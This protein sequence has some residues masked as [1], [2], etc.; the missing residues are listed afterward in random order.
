MTAESL[1]GRAV[2]GS[3]APSDVE[4]DPVVVHGKRRLAPPLPDW[5]KKN[6]NTPMNATPT[7]TALEKKIA[8]AVHTAQ[9]LWFIGVFAAIFA[10]AFAK[11]R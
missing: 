9:N 8:P 6:L 4:M 5:L 7:P 10:G 3:A 2:T 1:A 11:G